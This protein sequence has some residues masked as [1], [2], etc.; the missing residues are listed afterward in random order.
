MCKFIVVL[1]RRADFTRERFLTFLRDVHGPLA[2]R[3]PDLVRY[4][5]NHVVADPSR[6]DPGWDAV[7]E[8]WWPDR[9][10]MEA[11]WQAPEGRAATADLAAFADLDRTTWSIVEEH[12][13]R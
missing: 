7:V 12:L 10:S 8:L 13:R 4:V 1:Y 6:R 9:P 5:Q 2:E 3:L 11:A